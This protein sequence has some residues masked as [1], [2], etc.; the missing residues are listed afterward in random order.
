MKKYA[1]VG[2][3]ILLSFFGGLTV[4][5]SS[6]AENTARSQSNVQVAPAISTPT[7]CLEPEESSQLLD[8]SY[9]TKFNGAAIDLGYDGV[10]AEDVPWVVDSAKITPIGTGDMLVNMGDTLYR[11]DEQRYVIWSSPTGPAVFDYTYVESTNLI[12]T[13]AGD[14]IMVI[15]NATTGAEEFITSRNGSA[16]YGVTEKYGDD[17][18]LV[19]DNF[20]MYREKFRRDKIE[21]M[22]DGITCW[23]GTKILWRLD[24][25]PDATLVVNGKRI[26][27]VT[28]SKKAVYVNEIFPP[29]AK[30]E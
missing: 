3:G 14:N 9:V 25:P 20:V 28:R 17:M 29:Q 18:C 26:L 11:L 10:G 19:T 15:L 24:F 23:R 1:F 8:D 12:Y 6:H 27:A 4:S 2:F 21:P 16:A 30:S 5:Y 22:K 13:T 7:P